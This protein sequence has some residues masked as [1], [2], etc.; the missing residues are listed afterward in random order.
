MIK[1]N[2]K[3]K[4]EWVKN[5]GGNMRLLIW[6]AFK[7]VP[8]SIRNPIHLDTVRGSFRTKNSVRMRSNY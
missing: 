4:T 6:K 8:V 7:F 1:R 5:A 3:D 2:K